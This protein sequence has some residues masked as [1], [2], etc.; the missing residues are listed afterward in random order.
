MIEVLALELDNF[1]VV[2]DF[3]LTDRTHGP[4]FDFAI[5]LRVL[6]LI[7][8]QTLKFPAHVRVLIKSPSPLL[9][10]LFSRPST[11]SRDSVH[12][13]SVLWFMVW[14]SL[15]SILNF[16]LSIHIW[17]WTP[18]KTDAL[19]VLKVVWFLPF[20]WSILIKSD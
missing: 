10:P 13:D 15:L 12:F 16:K 4:L 18:D 14:V 5:D 17:L 7:K 9:K 20:T 11:H 1:L 6:F 8:G 3:F 19:R 2:P